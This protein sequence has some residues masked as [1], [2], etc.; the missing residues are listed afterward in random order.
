MTSIT[1]RNERERLLLEQL[2]AE[3]GMTILDYADFAWRGIALPKPP[4]INAMALDQAGYD[5]LVLW[6]SDQLYRLRYA[7]GVIPRT[8][9][10]G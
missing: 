2:A 6:Y 5:E 9:P 8:S 7:A 4:P 3:H 1:Y 10:V